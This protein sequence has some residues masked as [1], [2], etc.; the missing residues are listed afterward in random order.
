MTIP[1]SSTRGSRVTRMLK[2][3]AAWEFSDSRTPM[4]S[5]ES[6]SVKPPGAV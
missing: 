5:L 2:L 4:I 3:A 1:S 6:G